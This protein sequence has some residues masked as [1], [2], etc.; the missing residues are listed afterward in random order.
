MSIPARCSIEEWAASA[1]PV[2]TIVFSLLLVACSQNAAPDH[3]MDAADADPAIGV[4]RDQYFSAI[5]PSRPIPA[6]AAPYTF[7][8]YECTGDCSGHAAGYEWAEQNGIEAPEDCG[9]SS[10]SFIEGCEE[11]ANDQRDSYDY[12]REWAEENGVVDESECADERGNFYAGC[13]EY[14]EGSSD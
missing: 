7:G 1:P 14:A 6:I 8:A 10:S 5:A 4:S 11:Y 2:L 9:G 3:S 12:G 13:S